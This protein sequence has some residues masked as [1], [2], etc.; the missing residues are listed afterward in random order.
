MLRQRVACPVGLFCQG[1]GEAGSELQGLAKIVI[2]GASSESENARHFPLEWFDDR[3]Y[4]FLRATAPPIASKYGRLL[5]HDPLD[6]RL[7]ESALHRREKTPFVRRGAD[8]N[9]FLGP[10]RRKDVARVRSRDV[11]D[12]DRDSCVCDALRNR[13][14]DALGVPIH[15]AIQECYRGFGPPPLA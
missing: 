2:S 15:G 10:E 5:I 1:F 8:A 7:L 3:S 12:L 13:V 11:H 14:H 6:S 4:L 9:S